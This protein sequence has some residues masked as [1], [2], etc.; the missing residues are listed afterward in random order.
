M[1]GGKTPIFG[2]HPVR[3]A[4]NVGRGWFGNGTCSI[5]P[6]RGDEKQPLPFAKRK[7]TRASEATLA[8]EVRITPFV[9]RTG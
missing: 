5:S 2:R 1:E 7:G 8:G 6:K 3:R 9:I 4:G